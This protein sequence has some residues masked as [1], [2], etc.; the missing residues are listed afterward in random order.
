MA[1]LTGKQL[2]QLYGVLSAL[3][4][5]IEFVMRDDIKVAR[6]TDIPCGEYSY[7][8][9]KGETVVAIDKTI[10]SQLCSLHNSLNRL[11]KF[12][13]LNLRIMGE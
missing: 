6:V 5:G 10:G 9:N 2:N 4:E 7:T 11:Q 12:I 8:N 13:D 3:K 1:K